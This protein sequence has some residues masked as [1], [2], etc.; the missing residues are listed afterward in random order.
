MLP[1][2]QGIL[3]QGDLDR[4]SPVLGTPFGAPQTNQQRY[5]DK[6]MRT[7]G[8]EEVEGVRP[9]SGARRGG[10]EVRESLRGNK[11][12]VSPF[13]VGPEHLVGSQWASPKSGTF[14]YRRKKVTPLLSVPEPSP[15]SP[16]P[17][18]HERCSFHP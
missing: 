5:R 1:P 6:R 7:S 12:C 14:L 17:R 10:V 13:R 15:L 4:Q 11:R 18:G 16:V 3:P 8:P 9:D 2:E